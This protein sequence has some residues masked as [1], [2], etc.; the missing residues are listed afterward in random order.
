VAH[1]SLP[2]GYWDPGLPEPRWWKYCLAR[3]YRNR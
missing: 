3:C 1:P 2:T